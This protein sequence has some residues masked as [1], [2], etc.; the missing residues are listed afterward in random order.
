MLRPLYFLVFTLLLELSGCVP[1]AFPSVQSV[2]P[3]QIDADAWERLTYAMSDD[4]A[5]A[6][7]R[8]GAL[9]L[10]PI[11]LTG[12]GDYRVRAEYWG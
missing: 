7:L 12:E 4:L 11:R 6:S 10:Q 8:Q 3:P 1:G 9:S 5:S 2:P